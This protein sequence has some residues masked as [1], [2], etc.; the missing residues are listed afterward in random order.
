M[1]LPLTTVGR[2]PAGAT[3]ATSIAVLAALHGEKQSDLAKALGMT[4]YQLS[5]RLN[6]KA[7]WTPDELDAIAE[8]YRIPV[9]LLF[10]P[11]DQLLERLLVAGYKPAI[12]V[13]PL[14]PDQTELWDPALEVPYNHE[15]VLTS[16]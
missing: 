16:V 7:R 4:D 1:A 3:I 6:L 5:R 11:A 8:H 13:H 2:Q 15:P 12:G 14:G 9:G 10:T